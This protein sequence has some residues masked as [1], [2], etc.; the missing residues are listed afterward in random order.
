VVEHLVERVLGRSAIITDSDLNL[1][2]DNVHAGWW[3]ALAVSYVV[4]IQ[5]FHRR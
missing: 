3:T 4:K 5:Y 1:S 2:S